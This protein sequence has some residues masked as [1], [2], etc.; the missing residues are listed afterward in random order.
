MSSERDLS[1]T[2]AFMKD[3]S[4]MD[5]YDDVHILRPDSCHK[6]LTHTCIALLREIAAHDHDSLQSV[7]TALDMG[8]TR[9]ARNCT[10]LAE[11]ELIEFEPGVETRKKPRLAHED[12]LV[13]PI[14][15]N[16]E[17]VVDE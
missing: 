10:R 2:V 11:Y 4:E 7:A 16:G 8:H 15:I 5:G 12:I 3:V 17:V 14:V 1:P 9:V 13:Q 6:V